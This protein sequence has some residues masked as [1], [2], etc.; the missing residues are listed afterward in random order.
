MHL[1]QDVAAPNEFS[2]NIELRVCRPFAIHF[3]L[4]A[5]DVIF[6]NVD[7][8]VISESIF[9]KDLDHKVGVSTSGG[10][11]IAFHEKDDFVILDPLVDELVG[12]LSG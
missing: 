5:D 7:R 10:F 11:R 12:I 9:L 3:H 2:V 4:L 6:Q 8:L 1:M